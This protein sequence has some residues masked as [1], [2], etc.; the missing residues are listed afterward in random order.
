MARRAARLDQLK[1]RF[2]EQY[3]IVPPDV[4]RMRLED[5][6]AWKFGLEISLGIGRKNQG[7]GRRGRRQPMMFIKKDGPPIIIEV[8]VGGRAGVFMPTGREALE[9][10]R[11]SKNIK[12]GR[13]TSTTRRGGIEAELESPQSNSR[14]FLLL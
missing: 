2:E 5:L 10:K 9:G 11:K 8:Y 7:P 4:N 12:P 3:P 13:T 6:D 1:K 14:I